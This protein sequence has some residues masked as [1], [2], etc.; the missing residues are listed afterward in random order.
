MEKER[1][2]ER[3][4]EALTSPC[5]RLRTGF[6]GVPTSAEGCRVGVAGCRRWGWGA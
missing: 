4:T 5:F 6:G 1:E 2:R 3:V